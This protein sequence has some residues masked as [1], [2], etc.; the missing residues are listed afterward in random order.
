[1]VS[2]SSEGGLWTGYIPYDELPYL[3]NPEEGFIVTANNKVIGNEYPYMI[4]NDRDW[5]EAYRATRIRTM[6]SDT[7]ARSEKITA[8]HI[9]QW[10]SDQTTVMWSQN[11]RPI[12]ASLD[13]QA[14]STKAEK[15][16]QEILQWDGNINATSMWALVRF[17]SI[18]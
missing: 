5:E 17:P 6:I 13:P 8:A 14:L 7:I 2:N 11:L 16:R 18:A 9:Q 15:F 3:L 4:L 1:M 10:Q 12:L